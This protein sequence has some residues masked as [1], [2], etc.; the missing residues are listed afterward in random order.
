[1]K[2]LLTEMIMNIETGKQKLPAD[3]QAVWDRIQADPKLKERLLAEAI[4]MD[5]KYLSGK[6]R[7]KSSPKKPVRR[8]IG[9]Y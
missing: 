2:K 7:R 5:T 1:M 6:S 8:G 9:S 3:M 4:H